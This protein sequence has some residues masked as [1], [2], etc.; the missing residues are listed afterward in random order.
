MVRSSTSNPPHALTLEHLAEFYDDHQP[1]LVLIVDVDGTL[2]DVSSITYLVDPERNNGRRDFDKFH[3]MSAHCPP[4]RA[5]ID[6]LQQAR[7]DDNVAII[8]LTGRQRKFDYLT[9]WWLN[10]HDVPYDLLMM[11][12]NGDFRADTIIKK[13]KLDEIRAAGF[14]VIGAIDDNPTIL[15]LWRGECIPMV[16]EVPGWNARNNINDTTDSEEV[17]QEIRAKLLNSRLP[18]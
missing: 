8:A 6:D 1:K 17:H 11:R 18:D 5:T 3:E 15:Q 4:I 2:V 13:E 7:S 14:Y 10:T 9:R 12:P 16:K